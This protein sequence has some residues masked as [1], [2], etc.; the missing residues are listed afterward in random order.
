MGPT[1]GP[2]AS[3]PTAGNRV[4]M[5]D[6]ASTIARRIISLGNPRSDIG[7]MVMR[8]LVWRVGQRAGDGGTT[9]ALI[10]RKLYV[11]GMRLNTA[12]YN[13]VRMARGVEQGVKVAIE[14]LRKLARPISGETDLAAVARTITKDGAPQPLLG[15]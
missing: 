4:E 15:R 5:L 3:G 14:A 12:G 13:T 9:A 10:A 11:D 8:S 6:D 2:V 7:A 1:G